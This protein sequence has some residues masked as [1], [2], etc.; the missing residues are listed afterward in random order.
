[1]PIDNERPGE[2]ELLTD[3]KIGFSVNPSV[4]NQVTLR[5]VIL[6]ESLLNP[7]LQTTIRVHSYIHELPPKI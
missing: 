3:M 6:A 7:G 4:L 5:E 2:L 1:M